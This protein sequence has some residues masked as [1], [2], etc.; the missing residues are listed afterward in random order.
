MRFGPW[1]AIREPMATGSVR[2]Y[3][4]ES[5]LGEKTDVAA[6]HPDLATRAARFM[7][8]AHVP[9]PAWVVR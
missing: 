4:L 1:K 7:H 3:D 5:D 9:D 2:L 8:E 6:K